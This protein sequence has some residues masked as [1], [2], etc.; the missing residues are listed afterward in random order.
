M[1]HGSVTPVSTGTFSA[2]DTCC[3]NNR[4]LFVYSATWLPSECNAG[5]GGGLPYSGT[6]LG[7]PNGAAACTS[8]VVTSS[9]P[10]AW[11]PHGLWPDEC[12]GTYKTA[13]YCDAVLVPP[14]T[15]PSSLFTGAAGA[16][17]NFTNFS[18]WDA[19]YVP[20]VL[21]ALQGNP[22]LWALMNQTWVGTNPVTAN[23]PSG[24]GGNLIHWA[25]EY[26]KHGSCISTIQPGCNG[27]NKSQSI[28][29]YFTATL[30][31]AGKLPWYDLLAAKGIYPSATPISLAAISAAVFN[32]FGHTVS[33]YCSNNLGPDGQSKY[34]R[35][36]WSYFMSNSPT[37]FYMVDT[38]SIQTTSCSP[39][40]YYQPNPA[41][42]PPPPVPS[43]PPPL[44]PQ[45]SPP[46]PVVSSQ[47]P[48]VSSAPLPV[49]SAPPPVVYPQLQNSGAAAGPSSVML[50]GAVLSLI[51]L[52]AL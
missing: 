6:M 10:V 8:T 29:D 11:T 25:H 21:T 15:L 46:P 35:E 22:T 39:L 3:I 32:T 13:Q 48:L 31:I 41:V 30:A 28:V 14:A 5:T 24:Y 19:A 12:D 18:S 47:P 43:P 49:S 20:Q 42:M 1:L 36:I 16:W 23:S 52:L 40:V 38:A 17:Y 2:P 27:G 50:V 33:F 4:G 7:V 44:L 45:S 26:A 37:S 51:A 9:N 34:L